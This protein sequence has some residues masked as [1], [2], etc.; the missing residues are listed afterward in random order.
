MNRLKFLLSQATHTII[1]T[2][3]STHNPLYPS[4]VIALANAAP[5]FKNLS[6]VTSTKLMQ[7][8][9]TFSNPMFLLADEG[10]PRLLFFM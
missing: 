1:T 7:I 4:L 2:N 8:F 9:A 5:Y 10:H 3:A 6:P